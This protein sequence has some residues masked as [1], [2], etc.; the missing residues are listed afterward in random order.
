MVFV[1]NKMSKNN[2]KDCW[3]IIE[4]YFKNKHLEQLVR[5]QIESYNDFISRQIPSTIQMF[6]S[7][8]IASEHDYN[9][10]LGKYRLEIVVTFD[11]FGIYR[12][13]IHENNGATK[14]M[15]PQEARLRNFSYSSNMTINMNIKYL[16]RTGDNL[17]N[18]QTIYKVLPKIHIGKIPIML[19]SNICILTQYKHMSHNE[20][21]E[22]LMDPGG[23]FIINGSEKTCLGQERAA[24]NIIYCFDINKNNTKWELYS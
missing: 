18:L 10:E 14:L 16:I 17:E 12:P 19:R 13:Q 24:E 20:T 5:H 1:N 6:N 15:F 22:C 21:G 7:I 3:T 9:K 8:N 4:S 11:N 2:N 23:Y